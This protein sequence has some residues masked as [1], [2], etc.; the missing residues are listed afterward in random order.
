MSASDDRL[1]RRLHLTVGERLHDRDKEDEAAGRPTLDSASR[2]QFARHLIREEITRVN[3][4]RLGD[5][6][7]VLT[8][9]DETLLERGVF[10]RLFGL[11]RLQD[12]IDDPQYSDIKVNGCDVVWLTRR[13]GTKFQGEPVASSD[14]ELIEI[15]Q[16]QARRGSLSEKKWDY[17]NPTLDLQ[18]PSGDRLNALA[19]VVQRPSISIRRHNFD[20]Y[21]LKQL[22]G[23]TMSESLYH[24]CRAAVKGHFNVLVAGGTGAGKTTLLRCLINEIDSEERIV[25][26]EDSLEL[27]L[28]RFGDRHP[29]LIEAEAREANMEGVGAVPMHELVRNSLRM[30]PDRVIVGE[31]RGTEVL[32]MMLA[33]SQGSDGSL[34]SVHADSSHAVFSRLQ[35]YMAMTPERF[36]VKSTNLMVANAIH[37]IIHLAQLPTQE[38]VITSVREV[39]GADGEMMISNE[40]Y[41]PDETRRAV[42]AYPFQDATMERLER[43]GFDRGWH[44]PGRGAWTL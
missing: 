13:N 33:M 30:D 32:P 43:A 28:H 1:V 18:L 22:V 42:P 24:F 12:Y 8:P 16:T 25:T 19:W 29:D 26:V 40:V 3:T 37:F 10:N 15:I 6:G 23:P 38:R 7:E 31:I 21:R 14:E 41:T 9:E 2:Q 20:L 27:G 4:D 39:V 34:S 44:T 36:D 5:G 35:M 17:S 11:G